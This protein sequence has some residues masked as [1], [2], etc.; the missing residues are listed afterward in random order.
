MSLL[1]AKCL[2]CGYDRR[3]SEDILRSYRL[4]EETL[5]TIP[6]G[7]GWCA[8]CNQVTAVEA[9]PSLSSIDA[10]IAIRICDDDGRRQYLQDLRRWREGRTESAKCLEC[11]STKFLQ[12]EEANWD[13][14]DPIGPN[15]DYRPLI[16]PGCGGE[17]TLRSIGFSQSGLWMKYTPDGDRLAPS[18]AG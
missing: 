11:G 7:Y 14:D 3:L 9:M 12:F 10:E 1:A 8:Q 4:D 18:S 15:E 6:I 17:L 16:H 5:V 2:T 13:D